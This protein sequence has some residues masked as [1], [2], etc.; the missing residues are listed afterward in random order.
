MNDDMDAGTILTL[1]V[2]VLTVAGPAIEKMLKKAGKVDKAKKVRK[3]VD[4]FSTDKDEEWGN[5]SSPY[6]PGSEFGPEPAMQWPAGGDVVSADDTM[7]EEVSRPVVPAAAEVRNTPPVSSELLEGGY[8][9]VRDIIRERQQ[10]ESV[11]P[12]E[13]GTKSGFDIDPEKLV[14]YSEIM[15]PKWRSKDD[16]YFV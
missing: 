7:P 14:V 5:A 2:V 1:L 13:S 12:K 3:I 8:R 11:R 9:S 6:D 16:P 4:T 15:K 10:K